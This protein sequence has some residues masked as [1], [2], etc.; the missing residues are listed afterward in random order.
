[1][2]TSTVAIEPLAVDKATAAAMLGGLS[3]STF[4]GLVR[5][6]PLLAP[7]QISGRRVAWLVDNLREWLATRPTSTILPPKNCQRGRRAKT[8]TE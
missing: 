5:T 2:N 7:V 1:M 8:T 3:V 4:E 6:E